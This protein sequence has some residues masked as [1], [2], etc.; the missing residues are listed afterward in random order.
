MST[1]TFHRRLHRSTGVTPMQWL[2]NQRPAHARS[3][4]ESADLTVET[5]SRMA[6]LGTATNLRRHFAAVLGVTPADYRRTFARREP[7][8]AGGP[9]PAPGGGPTHARSRNERGDPPVAS[10][11]V[12]ALSRSVPALTGLAA[13]DPMT[14]LGALRRSQVLATLVVGAVGFGGMFAVY[15]YIATTLTDV[16]G[17]SSG[18]V[19]VVPAL[20]G[21]GMVAGH[22][23]GAGP[24]VTGLLLFTLTLWAARRA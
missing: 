7:A 16:A 15:T 11:T 14:E 4:L 21:L 5:V 20:F 8:P 17:M 24:A 1:R 2:L 6:G 10:L 12:A 3:L 19:P 9:P 13:T 22:M 23:V 18:T